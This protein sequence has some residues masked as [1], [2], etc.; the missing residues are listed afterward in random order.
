MGEMLNSWED[1][2]RGIYNWGPKVVYE[3]DCIEEVSGAYIV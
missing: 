1:E 3:S 2:D